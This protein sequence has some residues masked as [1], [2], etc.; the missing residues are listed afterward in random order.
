[1]AGKWYV[2][3]TEPRMEYQAAQS[4][5]KD[6]M[7]IWFPRVNSSRYRQRQA[8][9]PL[10]PGYIF[11]KGDWETT[12]W[13]TFSAAHRVTG[14]L[15]FGDVVPSIP[16]EVMDELM[17]SVDEMNAA[18]GLWRRFKVGQTVQVNSGTFQ[19]LAEVIEEAR[20]PAARALV[21]MQFMGR[22]VQTQVPWVDLHPSP[23]QPVKP[24]DKIE[25]VRV[26]RR[27]RGR[28]RWVRGQEPTA[29]IAQ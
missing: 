19:G 6:E 10:F 25:K 16:N 1:M 18:N 4:L 15:K 2:M 13:P 8:D 14:W 27:T 17:E 24:A 21:L 29:A 7:E 5:T 12:G 3:R 9:L 26:P 28:G 23:N 22:M 11:I 20:S